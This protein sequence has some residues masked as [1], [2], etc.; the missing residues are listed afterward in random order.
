MK[1]IKFLE[2]CELESFGRGHPDNQ[3]YAEGE[4][5]TLRNDQADR[6]L[7]RKKADLIED[8]GPDELEVAGVPKEVITEIKDELGRRNEA[9][10]DDLASQMADSRKALDA[11]LGGGRTE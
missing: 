8:L 2:D 7:N 4:T 1:T 11:A 3:K 5:Q 6:W 9:D 10:L